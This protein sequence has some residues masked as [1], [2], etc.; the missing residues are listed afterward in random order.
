MGKKWDYD[1]P[2]V[3]VWVECLRVLKPGGHI[4]CACGTRTQHRM[5]V[6]IEDAGFEIRDIVAWIYGCLSEDTEIL[7]NNGWKSYK[8]IDGNSVLCF[9]V[10]RES[11]EY[12]KPTRKFLYENTYPAY[13]IQSDYTDQIVSRNHRCLVE[14]EG[15]LVFIPAEEL[16]SLEVVPTLSEDFHFI[17]ERQPKVLFKTVQWLLSWSGLEKIWRNG[18]RNIKLTRKQNKKGKQRGKEPCLEGWS[19]LFQKTWE[20]CTYKICKMFS[21]VFGYGKKRWLCNGTQINNGTISKQTSFKDRVCSSYQPQTT[22][23]QDRE[24]NV[25]QDKSGT[26]VIRR[27]T[28]KVTE[29]VYKGKVWCVEVPTGAFVARRNGKIFI[30]GNSG[31]PKS[32]NISK[33]LDKMAGT[34]VKGEILP[35][36]RTSKESQTG[37]AT[38]F[39]EKTATNPQ[40]DKAKQW[41]GWGTALKPSFEAWTLA[42]KPLESSSVLCYDDYIKEIIKCLL[43]SFANV[44]E[45]SLVLNQKE[46]KEGASIAQWL[47]ENNINTL[48]DLFVLTGMLQSYTKENMSLNIVLSWLNILAGIWQITNIHTIKTEL[49]LTTEL[50]ILKSTEWESILQNITHV[51][52]NQTNG[53]N[54][55][56]SDVVSLFNVLRL[57]LNDTLTLIAQENVSLVQLDPRINME[58]WTLARK[59]LSEKTVAQ[60]VLKYGTG[61]INIDGCRVGID[62]DDVNQRPNGSISF[63]ESKKTSM[64]NIGGRNP[65]IDGNTLDMDKGRF[66][67]NI[68]LDEVAGEMLDVQS[69]TLKTG[70]MKANVA[71]HGIWQERSFDN[72][73]VKASSGGA[74][75]FFYCAKASKS[76]RNAGLEKFKKG[77]PPAS[78]RSKPAEGRN[79]SLGE[80]RANFHPTVKPVALM[81]YLCRLITP[82]G[83]KVLDPFC[84]SGS[85]GIGAVKEGFNFIGIEKDPEY[86]KIAEAR[87]KNAIDSRETDLFSREV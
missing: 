49:N 20:L 77:E 32:H 62:K 41:D 76:E 64:F 24:S 53:L 4:L 47:A 34:Y 43:Q 3:E 73:E 26:Q 56:V 68:I 33:S 27:T 65:N 46:L 85:T 60:N 82:K 45:K 74:S 22:G 14:R 1:V 25:V 59:P 37:I 38:T 75:R 84:G 18:W 35:S 79:N 9:N 44:V 13:R 66:P 36:S 2:S 72:V 87:I 48:E 57:K 63:S 58:L 15:K 7:T 16:S 12:H 61:G 23:Q 19:N 39:R 55:Y 81:Q 51:K 78:A 30:T 8:E 54:V 67:A 42:Q 11:F 21:R 28:A 52:D 86:V 71:N 69:G 29:V 6:N 50:K 70:A 83:G 31:F 17:Q 40:S 10:D 80:P 5:A